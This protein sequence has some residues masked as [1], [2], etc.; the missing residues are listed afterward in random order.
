MGPNPNN[1]P[2]TLLVLSSPT[3]G[4]FTFAATEI[5]SK[6]SF[7]G[8]QQ[9]VVHELVGGVRAIDSMGRADAPIKWCGIFV[10][11]NALARAR[12]LDSLRADGA[13]LRLTWSEMAYAVSIKTFEAEYE[14]AFQIPYSI[15]CTV[16]MDLSGQRGAP[17][18]SAND[19][20]T[21]DMSTAAA[22]G[23]QVGDS[24]LTGLLGSLG[25]AISSVSSF[26]NATQST[27]NS[28]LMPIAAVTGQV[29][30]LIASTGNVLANVATL[31][32]I[33]PNNPIA[34]QVSSL[35]SQV[36]A[37]TQAPLLY[38]LQSVVGRMGVNLSS[39]GST[40]QTIVAG[41]GDLQHIAA[42]A[43]GDASAWT[44]IA[45]ANGLTDPQLLG[46]NTIIVPARPDGA[47]GVFSA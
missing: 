13:E 34:R 18:G 28:V 36:A 47:G 19:A 42:K 3:R 32:G 21:D 35:N 44:G 7:G 38:Q 22:L 11:K 26:A 4:E 20:I 33:L 6:I 17:S 1:Q 23:A 5:P 29:K 24:T 12:Q 41:G 43:Y 31:G 8:E 27:I 30:T 15:T 9:Q 14:Q 25:S 40:G 10:G 2:N 16:V 45:R 39:I 37:M 46:I